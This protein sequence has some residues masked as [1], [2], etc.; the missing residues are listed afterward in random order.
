M[1]NPRPAASPAGARSM[2]TPKPTT[3][4][5][6]RALIGTASEGFTPRVRDA[7][8]HALEH[9][10]DIALSPVAAV[11]RSSAR[12]CRASSSRST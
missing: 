5:E 3:L 12:R 7:A 2:S 1:P 9:P 4:D 10:N 11:A 6:L 8:R